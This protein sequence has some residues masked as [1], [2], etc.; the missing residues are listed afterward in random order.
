MSQKQNLI[1]A[2]LLVMDEHNGGDKDL[3]LGKL[4]SLP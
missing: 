1:I 4:L 2:K 3:T